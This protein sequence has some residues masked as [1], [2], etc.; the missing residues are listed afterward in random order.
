MRSFLGSSSFNVSSTPS[1]SPEPSSLSGVSASFA[2]VSA[3]ASASTFASLVSGAISSSS[4]SATPNSF[5]SALKSSSTSSSSS[6]G[7]AVAASSPAAS[8]PPPSKSIT[9]VPG[10]R[11]IGANNRSAISL[12]RITDA[13]ASPSS[14]RASSSSSR[15]PSPRAALAFSS[16]PRLERSYVSIAASRSRT[17]ISRC[18]RHA[19]RAPSSPTPPSSSF[20]NANPSARACR[21]IAVSS[22]AAPCRA[23]YLH[24]RRT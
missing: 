5:T 16:T 8:A 7:S 1:T 21:A 23:M 24:T 4:S 19:S 10:S 13:N 15:P 9:I 3:G 18:L 2:V 11:S 22:N 14:S 20:K 17:Y 6:L 12:A